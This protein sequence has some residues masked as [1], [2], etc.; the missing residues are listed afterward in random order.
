MYSIIPGLI[1]SVRVSFA[2]PLLVVVV[3]STS[4]EKDSLELEAALY[5]LRA[6]SIFSSTTAL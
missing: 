4:H 2:P 6:A 3:A 1:L 5:Q